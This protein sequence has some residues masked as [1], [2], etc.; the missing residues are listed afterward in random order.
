[1][2]LAYPLNMPENGEDDDTFGETLR[3]I[4]EIVGGAIDA[5][6]EA[7]VHKPLRN[8]LRKR[9]L[10]RPLCPGLILENDYYKRT[11]ES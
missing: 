5:I 11:A 10:Y 4:K 8:F 6:E 1:M 7:R 9:I 3:G 2:L